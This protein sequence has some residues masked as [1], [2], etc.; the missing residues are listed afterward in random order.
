MNTAAA[1][2]RAATCTR[3]NLRRI[4]ATDR[5]QTVIAIDRADVSERQDSRLLRCRNHPCVHTDFDDRCKGAHH[6]GA[7]RST[8]LATGEAAGVHN[9]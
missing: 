7:G 6:S 5:P 9:E 8:R 2:A 1:S 4:T 3:P